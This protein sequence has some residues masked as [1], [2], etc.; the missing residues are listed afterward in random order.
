MKRAIIIAASLCLGVSTTYA[1]ELQRSAKASQAPDPTVVASV[2]LPQSEP[3]ATTET[4]DSAT[5]VA[6]VPA[7]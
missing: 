1:C 6:E 7:N 3:V 4:E 2:V 5:S